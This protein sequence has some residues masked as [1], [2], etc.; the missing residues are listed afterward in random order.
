[1]KKLALSAFA[2]DPTKGSEPGN[3]W[4]WAIGL[5]KKGYEV[6]CFTRITGKE[7]IEKTLKSDNLIFHYVTLPLGGENLYFA[8]KA[9]MYLYYILW[10]WFAYRKA[11]HLHKKVGFTLAH[12]VTW[13][14][15]QMGSYMYK[16]GIP[17]I[18]GPAGGGQIAPKA[19]K[20]YFINDWTSEEKREKI[21]RW[22]L[23]YNPACKNM[24][25][26]AHAVLVSN[27]DT[28]RMVQSL[29]VKNVITT[30]D[31]AL[32]DSFFPVN[33]IIKQTTPGRLKLL[34]V[35]RFMPRK[36]ILL[37][38][39]VLDKLKE[40]PGITLTVVGDGEMKDSFLNKIVEYGLEKTVDWKGRVEYE[41][42]KGFYASH[43]VFIIASLRD[44]CPAQLIEAMAYNMPAVTLNLHGQAIIVNDLT[45]IRCECPDP[46]TAIAGL[47]EAILTLY[48]NPELVAQ[49]SKSAYDFAV[50]QTWDN[51]IDNIVQNHYPA[52]CLN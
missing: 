11:S 29:G 23:K 42:V 27:P 22:M 38:L 4:N 34:W 46:E 7:D 25:I 41:A 52:S 35:G 10:Q 12:H 47:K 36:G 19:F 39:D 17:F 3:G 16:L 20:H 5:A 8:S 6:H 30:L 14:S 44:S 49:K 18:F 37:I 45:G 2:C 28:E 1:M 43:D 48:N 50:Q 21:T 13:G 9:G 32:A 26:K 40:Y 24:L 33:P 31:A 51:K 15:T